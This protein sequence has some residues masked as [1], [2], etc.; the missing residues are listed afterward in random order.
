MS[1]MLEIELGEYVEVMLGEDD[2]G[3]EHCGVMEVVEL[4]EDDKVLVTFR[5]KSVSTHFSWHAL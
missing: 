1:Q 2:N 5:S 4:F 3:E